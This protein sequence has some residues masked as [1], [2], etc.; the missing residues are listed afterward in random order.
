VHQSNAFRERALKGFAADNQTL[1]TGT[2]IN[3]CC[4]HGLREVACPL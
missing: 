2:L 4:S 1:T 3:D